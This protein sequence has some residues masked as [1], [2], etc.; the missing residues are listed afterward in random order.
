MNHEKN[1]SHTVCFGCG[2][3]GQVIGKCTMEKKHKKNRLVIGEKGHT[4]TVAR[5]RKEKLLIW[6]G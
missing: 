6:A 3:T 2:E 4:K 5:T 1:K